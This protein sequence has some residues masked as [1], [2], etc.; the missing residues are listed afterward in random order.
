M[1][2]NCGTGSTQDKEVILRGSRPGANTPRQSQYTVRRWLQTIKTEAPTP[3]NEETLKG[4]YNSAIAVKGKCV[5]TVVQGARRTK[6]S[7]FAVPGQAQ[8]LLGRAACE[9]LGLVQLAYAVESNTQQGKNQGS[10]RSQSRGSIHRVQQCIL[11]GLGR[12]PRVHSMVLDP[13]VQPVVHPCRK[14]PFALRD[15]VKTELDRMETLEA[16]QSKQ[17]D[18]QFL[19][20]LDGGYQETQRWHPYLYGPQRS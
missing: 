18:W 16:Q 10:Q 15:R 1:R 4:S 11:R 20:W 17:S 9:K 13:K 3:Q 5:T 14:S 6:M 2:H 12:L 8:T 7:F 19:G